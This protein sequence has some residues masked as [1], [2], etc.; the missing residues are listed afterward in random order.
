VTES[1]LE[2]ILAGLV[3]I[4]RTFVA[5]EI[6]AATRVVEGRVTDLETKAAKAPESAPVDDRLTLTLDTDPDRVN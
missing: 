3:P 2:A 1:E 4:L 6:A 5:Q